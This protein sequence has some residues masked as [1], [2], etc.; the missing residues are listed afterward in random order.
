MGSRTLTTG[1]LLAALVLNLGWLWVPVGLLA[2]SVATWGTHRM[3]KDRWPRW[4]EA[5]VLLVA[6]L[7]F[8][9][10]VLASGLT[11]GTGDRQLFSVGGGQALDTVRAAS[12][13]VLP[14]LVL[15]QLWAWRSGLARQLVVAAA[16]VW[17]VLVPAALILGGVLGPETE[18]LTGAEDPSDLETPSTAVQ[19]LVMLPFVLAYTISLGA[20]G[21][22]WWRD[23]EADRGAG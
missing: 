18:E 13:L 15:P 17:L 16:A 6:W 12:G 10:L 4:L 20:A 1:L 21:V 9:Y 22:A 14:A 2:L 3:V 8:L 11:V 7:P 19:G 23:L 5:I